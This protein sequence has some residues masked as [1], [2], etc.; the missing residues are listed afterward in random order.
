MADADIKRAQAQAERDLDREAGWDA[1]HG[2]TGTMDAEQRQRWLNNRT[3]EILKGGGDLAAIERIAGTVF[4][5][6]TP[7]NWDAAD[8]AS[9]S[10]SGLRALLEAAHRAGRDA[11]NRERR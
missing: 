1:Y 7:R 5:N 3:R 6:L 2:R 8:F 11:A 9:V 4:P 10:R